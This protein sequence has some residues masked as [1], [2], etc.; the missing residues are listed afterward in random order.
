M[1]FLLR[2]AVVRLAIRATDRLPAF[3]RK[4]DVGLS[5]PTSELLDEVPPL[6]FFD[7][8]LF[9]LESRLL[10]SMVRFREK[11]VCDCMME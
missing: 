9:S 4:L 6:A 11:E 5:A 1:V 8:Q 2:P 3:D 7:E 10:P